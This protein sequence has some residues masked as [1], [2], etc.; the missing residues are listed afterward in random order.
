MSILVTGGLGY[1]GSHTVVELN[2]SGFDTIVIDNLSNSHISVLENLNKI[3]G[4]RNHFEN[5]DL[6]DKIDLELFFEKYKSIEG[7]IH[8]AAYKSVSESVNNPLKYFN[9]NLI[10]LIN[11]LEVLSCLLYTSPS[12]RDS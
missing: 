9:N 10:S 11:L 12:P 7:V 3:T 4:K 2:K 8:F 5:I 6:T 1:I